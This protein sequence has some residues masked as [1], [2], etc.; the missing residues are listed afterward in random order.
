[1]YKRHECCSAA[2]RMP[3][4]APTYIS[5]DK[6]DDHTTR[7]NQTHVFRQTHLH[8]TAFNQILSHGFD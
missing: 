5:Y 7:A 2:G 1:M 4:Q 6:A 8:F 3:E